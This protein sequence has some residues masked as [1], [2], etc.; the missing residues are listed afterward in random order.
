MR[1][2]A[3]VRSLY[4]ALVLVAATAVAGSLSA[5][6]EGQQELE[7][8]PNAAAVEPATTDGCQVVARIDGQV[9]LACEVLWQVNRLMENN[10]ESIPPDKYEQIREQLIKRLNAV[11]LLMLERTGEQT[12]ELTMASK[13][14]RLIGLGLSVRETGEILRKAPNYITAVT[15][16]AK[17][18]QPRKG[19]DRNGQ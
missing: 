9:V 17:R 6:A 14:E 12:P 4:H 16:N 2:T 3:Q 15:A 8:E 11:I 18:R 13:I 7:I 5:P 10:R 1:T 19:K